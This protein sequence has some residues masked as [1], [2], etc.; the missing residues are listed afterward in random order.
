[1]SQNRQGWGAVLR[2]EAA[3]IEDWVY[4]LST[5]FEPWTEI[6]GNDT[7]LRSSSLSDLETAEDVRARALDMIAYLNG[8]IALSQNA[9]P[10]SF[11]GTIRFDS[12]GHAHRFLLSRPLVRFKIGQLLLTTTALFRKP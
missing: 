3:D 9:G 12:E 7:I 8:A 10:V 1:M 2:G 6:Q 5:A 4:V 11:G